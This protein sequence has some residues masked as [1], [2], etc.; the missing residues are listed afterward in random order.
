MR[1]HHPK[2][3][4]FLI[5]VAIAALP[6]VL[7]STSIRTFREL[8]EQRTVY[9]RHRVALIAGRLENLPDGA[10]L[11]ALVESEPN[12]LDLR[13]IERSGEADLPELAPIWDG[14]ELFRTG[15]AG[16][17][18]RAYVPFHS[19]AGLRIARIDLNTAAADFLTDHARH[20]L[21]AAT[22][23]GL[24]LV[25]LSIY[26]V[27]AARRAAR[28]RLRQLEMEH[29][30]HIGKMSAM[31]AHEIR[32]PLGTI[33]GFAQ[34]AAEGSGEATRELLAP[35]VSEAQRL[36]ALVND[37]LAFGR[38]PVPSPRETEWNEIA[39]ALERH[40]RHLLAGRPVRF[41]LS[42]EDVK[43]RTDPLLVGQALLN[44]VR[45]AAEAIPEGADGEIRV[46]AEA[47]PDGVRI[48]VADNG[49]GLAE[50]AR[51]RLFEPFFTTKAFGTGLGLAITRK[52]AASL[53]GELDLRNRE[54]G[55]AEAVLAFRHGNHTHR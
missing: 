50:P 37:L 29:L 36:E 4:G 11:A 28:L 24:V 38:P 30:A 20:N 25:L 8:D 52:L 6:L 9:L 3:S 5:A 31:L 10:A 49:S 7:L 21:I 13:V 19:P 18:Y 34:L 26:A 17:A 41:T 47:T 27:W 12:L 42:G 33:K 48:T 45:N 53:G 14:R 39:G 43:W 54:Q 16:T 1:V 40:A 32:N 2:A 35:I 23:G 22:A 55:G 44:L 51:A 46:D 15:Q